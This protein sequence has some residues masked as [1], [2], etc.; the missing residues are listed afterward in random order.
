ML[1]S[2]FNNFVQI[3]VFHLYTNNF[4]TFTN[5]FTFVYFSIKKD[6]VMESFGKL[7]QMTCLTPCSSIE[8][9]KCGLLTLIFIIQTR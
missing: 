6:H 1:K 3:L 7:Q 4:H 9:I 8:L 5:I 2:C